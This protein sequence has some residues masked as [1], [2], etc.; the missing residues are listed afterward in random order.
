M[1]IARSACVEASATLSRPD[2]AGV[3]ARPAAVRTVGLLLEADGKEAVRSFL[4]D[5][6]DELRR[7]DVAHAVETAEEVAVA[8]RSRAQSI[9][10][11]TK[12]RSC[13]GSP[14]SK[15]AS[16]ACSRKQGRLWTWSE[17]GRD[18]I[19]ATIPDAHFERAV[20]A[21]KE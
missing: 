14:S 9:A 1:S 4:A 10:A 11:Q 2:M 21:A 20:M 16:S 5:L 17:G 13:S 7:L 18:D 15:A 19:L 8:Y 12:G 6:D 3:A